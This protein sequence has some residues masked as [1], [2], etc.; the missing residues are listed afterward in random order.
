MSCCVAEDIGGQLDGLLERCIPMQKNLALPKLTLPSTANA[1]PRPRLFERLSKSRRAVWISA[2][3]GAG[4]T[5]LVS[6]YI[7]ECKPCCLWYAI[8]AGDNDLASFFH[9]LGLAAIRVSPSYRKPLPALTPE[10]L[11]GLAVF[12]LRY[13]EDLYR[14]LEQPAVIVFD[15]YQEASPESPLHEVLRTACDSLP[16]GIRILMISRGEPPAAMARL[17][18][19]GKLALLGWE[20]LQLTVEE[21][22]LLGSSRGIRL[23][24]LQ[25]KK[26]IKE[27]RNYCHGWAAGLSLLLEHVNITAE[28]PLIDTSSREVLFNYF[29]CELFDLTPA[30]ARSLM[31]KTAF[32]A[33]IDGKMAAKLTEDAQAEDLLAELYHKNYF[34]S[35]R[36]N[37]EI[38][39][40][41]HPLFRDFLL[42]MADQSLGPDA[43]RRLRLETASLLEAA[44]LMEQAAELF[45]LAEDWM[46][47][48]R[49]IV[50][51]AHSLI[52][53]GRNQTLEQWLNWMPG[54]GANS[55]LYYWTGVC[56]LPF[57]LIEA[58][59]HF[60][61]AFTL[62]EPS[63]DS[64][65]IYLSWTGVGQT[66]IFEWR[67][68]KPLDYWIDVFDRLSVRHPAFPSPEIE[69]LVHSMLIYMLYR[70]PRHPLL[71]V[72][73]ERALELLRLCSDPALSM[74]L[75]SALIIYS[76]WKGELQI[77][78]CVMD[79]LRPLHW[80]P[81]FSPLAHTQWSTMAAVL[82]WGIGEHR[83]CLDHVAEGLQ[84]AS[85][86][87]VHIND[88]FLIAQGVYGCLVAGDLKKAGDF[89]RD[90]ALSIPSLT[91]LQGGHYYF[92]SALLEQQRGEFAKALE[93]ALI[94]LN[95]G[96]EAGAPFP[97]ALCNSAAALSFFELGNEK[98]GAEHLVKARTIGISIGSK[99]VEYLC[100]FTEARIA[101]ERKQTA[102]VREHL[103]EA[104]ALS[105][106]SG[107]MILGWWGPETM[108]RLY[109][110][111][112]EADIEADYVQALIR[113]IGLT[114]PSSGVVPEAW[115]VP[116]R[117]Y[118]LGRFE[119]TKD[120]EPMV[121][122]GKMPKKPLDLLQCIIAFGGAEVPSEQLCDQLWPDAEGDAAQRALI[123]TLHRLRQLLGHAESVTFS[124]GCLGLN[125][126]VA[127]V[128][129]WAFERYTRQ[130]EE[131][132]KACDETETKRLRQKAIDLYRGPFLK[133]QNC[134][135][136]VHRR[137]YLR[138]EFHHHVL[139]AGDDLE[140]EGL[141]E[142]AI[143]CYL[144]GINT[145]EHEQME[146]LN[147]RLA[148]C[149]KHFEREPEE[150][151]IAPKARIS[152][153]TRI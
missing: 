1:L 9:Y 55:W 17:R 46:S 33:H 92:I 70:Q 32:L 42:A 28:A 52:S 51:Y 27:L 22:L 119:I 122:H 8:D 62:F 124:G 113:R 115:P 53:H 69:T 152:G 48:E 54:Y 59:R 143:A 23:D 36:E 5:T 3:A 77:A 66:Y 135:K 133:N 61:R 34:L 12:A 82:A 102:R 117:I 136:T 15:N 41:F 93:Q 146:T 76:T 30:R 118:T 75:G 101:L 138:A 35:R 105:R 109:A 107:G 58:R 81:E 67:D 13:F 11:P 87:G 71:P 7:A 94:A 123:T 83:A 16:D 20:E 125:P 139:T 100:L 43:A 110:E 72:W 142:E 45:R 47:L 19:H 68:V 78:Y 120:G 134:P 126:H 131:A 95:M 18:L 56:R 128:D 89:L 96:I 65:G 112:L 91:F 127:W 141:V 150:K 106:L 90:L 31:I 4:K 145:D 99:A 29:V 64:T 85:A 151:T 140:N 74:Q 108:A 147:Q 148:R 103:K 26:R 2:P 149:Y 79:A 37:P 104:L 44:E 116:V 114:P 98:K 97:V 86:T 21:A 50:T 38:V 111:A 24:S 40:E 10:F 144:H 6:S 49:I 153:N 84:V 60:E 25:S 132:R 130:T 137:D 80:A 57:D 39:Y 14:R 88:A 63:N 73:T 121:Y 129:A